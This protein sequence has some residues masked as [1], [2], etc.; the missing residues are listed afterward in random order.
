MMSKH[1]QSPAPSLLQGEGK[2]V[3]S[4]LVPL[5]LRERLEGGS[6]FRREVQL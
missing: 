2:N 6:F 4:A 3:L 5:L 1:P